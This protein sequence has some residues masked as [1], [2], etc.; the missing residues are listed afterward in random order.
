MDAHVSMYA[1]A[2]C[3]APCQLVLSQRPRM[4]KTHALGADSTSR[5]THQRASPTQAL[6]KLAHL[7]VGE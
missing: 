7:P 5:L 3:P 4:R 2:D 6:S 1:C